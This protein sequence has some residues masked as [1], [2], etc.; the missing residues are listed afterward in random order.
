MNKLIIYCIIMSWVRVLPQQPE[1]KK[2]AAKVILLKIITIKIIEKTYVNSM[3][4]F[5]VPFLFYIIPLKSC[6][7]SIN[8][9]VSLLILFLL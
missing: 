7:I 1:N 2:G 9:F 3:I 6:N 4:F 8:L 5:T